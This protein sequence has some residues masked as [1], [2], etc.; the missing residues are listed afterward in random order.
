MAI[1]SPSEYNLL[2][3]G[4]RGYRR[5]I[6]GFSGTAG[7]EFFVLESL[8]DGSKFSATNLNGGQN[9][10]TNDTWDKGAMAWGRFAADDVTWIAGSFRAWILK[11]A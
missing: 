10:D 7:E 11:P 3:T 8:E 4:G 5:V 1:Q 2:T 6:T 9:P